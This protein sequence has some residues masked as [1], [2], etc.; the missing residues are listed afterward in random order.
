MARSYIQDL[1]AGALLIEETKLWLELHSKSGGVLIEDFL[2]CLPARSETT[3]KRYD[4]VIRN[5][6][7][8]ITVKGLDLLKNSYGDSFKQMLLL[9]VM[10]RT[11]IVTDFINGVVTLFNSFTPRGLRGNAYFA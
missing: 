6:L 5:R 10:S 9:L 11:Q 8:D 1:T 7:S 3:V 4:T 2:T